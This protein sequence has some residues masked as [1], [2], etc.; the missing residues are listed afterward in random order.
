ML[1]NNI[2]NT[3]THTTPHTHTHTHVRL[4]DRHGCEKDSLEIVAE[5]VKRLT[6]EH[7]GDF[8]IVQ[9]VQLT[10]GQEV[11]IVGRVDG[12]SYS[13]YTMSNCKK[14]LKKNHITIPC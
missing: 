9:L 6:R 4:G 12:L 5:Q 7:F 14:N 2:N 10:Q 1:Y 8:S 13:K 3:H 11:D